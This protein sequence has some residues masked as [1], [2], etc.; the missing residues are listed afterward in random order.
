MSLCCSKLTPSFDPTNVLPWPRCRTCHWPECQCFPGIV[1]TCGIYCSTIWWSRQ[2]H[3]GC[4]RNREEIFSWDRW[5]VSW[6]ASARTP[7][8]SQCRCHYWWHRWR[9]IPAPPLLLHAGFHKEA[10]LLRLEEGMS[11]FGFS[12]LVAS[13]PISGMTAGR[14]WSSSKLVGLEVIHLWTSHLAEGPSCCSNQ[15]LC[16]LSWLWWDSSAC[17][18]ATHLKVCVV[19]HQQEVQSY[20]GC[21]HLG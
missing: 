6:V 17:H 18:H 20:E 1:L 3:V 2:G 8:W 16:P 10:L 15:N 19:S 4:F 7:G 9:H 12:R 5:I 13:F 14:P 11:W 21:V